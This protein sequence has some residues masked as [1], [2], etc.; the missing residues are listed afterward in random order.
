MYFKIFSLLAERYLYKIYFESKDH[1][2]KVHFQRNSLIAKYFQQ[3]IIRRKRQ[4]NTFENAL[5]Y[6]QINYN[7]IIMYILH[8]KEFLKILHDSKNPQN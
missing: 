5:L 7:I 6:A 8:E 4:L 3:Y 1:I 2:S